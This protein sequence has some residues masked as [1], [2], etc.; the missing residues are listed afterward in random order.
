MGCNQPQDATM[1]LI[2][3]NYKYDVIGLSHTIVLEQSL[4]T[5]FWKDII[6]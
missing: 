5:Y 3:Y 1:Y 2:H 4:Y 6:L